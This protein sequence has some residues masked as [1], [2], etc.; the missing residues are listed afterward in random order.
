M[1]KS[2]SVLVISAVMLM[3]MIMAGC[4]GAPPKTADGHPPL[5]EYCTVQ[6]RRDALGAGSNLPVP[7]T[8]GSINNAEVLHI[9]R[10]PNR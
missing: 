4:G 3:A 9:R 10:S 7:P 2:L 5:G 6:F 8:T 1:T